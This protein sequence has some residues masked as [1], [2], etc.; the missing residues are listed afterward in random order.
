MFVDKCRQKFNNIFPLS[1]YFYYFLQNIKIFT[2][3]HKRSSTIAATEPKTNKHHQSQCNVVMASTRQQWWLRT[4]W[5]II[6][7]WAR[8]EFHI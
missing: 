1:V 2:L 3:S 4:Y 8:T 6:C 5:Y 7:K